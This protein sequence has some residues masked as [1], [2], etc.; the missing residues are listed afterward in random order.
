MRSSAPVK[1]TNYVRPAGSPHLRRMSSSF[2]HHPFPHPTP[3][4]VMFVYHFVTSFYVLFLFFNFY[5]HGRNLTH[6]RPTSYTWLHAPAHATRPL[7]NTIAV[8]HGAHFGPR[9]RCTAPHRNASHRSLRAW[10][11][12]LTAHTRQRPFGY[13][14]LPRHRSSIDSALTTDSDNRLAI[15]I[16]S[17]TDNDDDDTNNDNDNRVRRRRRCC[18]RALLYK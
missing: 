1:P 9:V 17:M 10:S 15:S 12:D 3:M 5:A 13:P 16:R 7:H 6:T 8:N 2:R 18:P 14:A 4:A 11:D